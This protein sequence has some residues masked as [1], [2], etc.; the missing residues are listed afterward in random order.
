MRPKFSFALYGNIVNLGGFV[1]HSEHK[2]LVSWQAF[3][4]N[5]SISVAYRSERV[6]KH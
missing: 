3:E 6:V 1:M 5:R 2:F 4:D